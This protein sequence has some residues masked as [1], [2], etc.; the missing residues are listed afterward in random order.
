M[1]LVAN[2]SRFSL[3]VLMG[4]LFPS[5]GQES[6]PQDNVFQE[7][8]I[9]SVSVMNRQHQPVVFL[10]PVKFNVFED[11]QPQSVISVSQ[12]E[13]PICMGLVV[14]ISGSMR[15]KHDMV[16]GQLVNLVK[17]RGGRDSVFVV[18]FN[19]QPYLDQD[20]TT[21]L[22]KIE[23]GLSRGNPRGGTA[24]Y[25]AVTAAADHLAK[26]HA[27]SRRVLLV[28]TDG[29]DN[30]SRYNLQ[31]TVELLQ[32]PLSPTIYA[33]ALPEDK[34]WDQ[35]SRQALEALTSTTGGTAF[36]LGGVNELNK[37]SQRLLEELQRQYIIVYTRNGAGAGRYR[38]ITVEVGERNPK[39][40][41]VRTR[42]GIGELNSNRQ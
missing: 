11:G 27:C 34:P 17:A 42:A 41:I 32:N 38:R 15:H 39:E 21:D 22:E 24:L 6:P 2:W 28:V 4:V 40:V 25:D 1:R 36:F 37:A 12:T 20:L 16:I 26:A 7:Q 13:A 5:F 23:K 8:I 14:D 33:F 3:F 30:E 35:K 10:D 29:K 31:K 9:L 19:D 18:N